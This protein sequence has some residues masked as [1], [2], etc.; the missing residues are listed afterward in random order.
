M[1][2]QVAYRPFFAT[3]GP[4]VLIEPP[5]LLANPDCI[6]IGAGV[7][8]RAGARLEAVKANGRTPVIRIGAGTH[9][10]QNVHIV[11]HSS[12]KI[13]CHVSIT[14]NCAIVDVTHPHD[15][16]INHPIGPLIRDEPS[17]VEIGDCCFLG[18]GSVVLPNVRL[19]AGCVVG[20]NSV[21]TRSFPPGSI[22]AGSPARLLGSRACAVLSATSSHGS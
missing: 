15:L 20:A 3:Y 13:G 4:G 17:F 10:E 5:T 14:A 8:V 22:L 9:I 21:V 11:G 16:P 12:I 6:H 7:H 18:T 1:Y 2:G 19:G